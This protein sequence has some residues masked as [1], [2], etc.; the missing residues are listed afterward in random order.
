M[1]AD[2][3][4]WLLFLLLWCVDRGGRWKPQDFAQLQV[5]VWGFCSIFLHLYIGQ[6]EIKGGYFGKAFP[7]WTH[8]PFLSISWF[9]LQEAF[10]RRSK[11]YIVTVVDVHVSHWIAT[12]RLHPTSHGF[13]SRTTRSPS[14]L[15]NQTHV[16]F[17]KC[18]SSHCLQLNF[19]WIRGTN[20]KHITSAKPSFSNQQVPQKKK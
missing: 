2:S 10:K 11:L 7:I 6:P 5:A 16:L 19:N 3:V 20:M 17:I 13:L 4:L 15:A 1:V 9:D 12:E 18:I 14:V 8:H